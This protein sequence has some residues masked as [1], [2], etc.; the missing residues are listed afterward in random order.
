MN[1]TRRHLGDAY[2]VSVILEWENAL[3][4]GEDRASDMLRELGAQLAERRMI[5][6][7]ATSSSRWELISVFDPLCIT[8]AAVREAVE[9]SLDAETLSL[10]CIYLPAPSADYYA[11]KNL[12]VERANGIIVVLL[13]SDVVPDQG[14]LAELLRPFESPVVSIV[15]SACYIEPRGLVRKVLALIWVFEPRGAGSGLRIVGDR[16]SNS[17]AIANSTAYRREVFLSNPFDDSSGTARGS[18]ARQVARF[19]AMGIPVFRNY[20][21][22]LNHPAPVGLVAFPERSIA[23][24]RDVM[25]GRG[26]LRMVGSELRRG[27]RLFHMRSA[28]GLSVWQLPAALFVAFAWWGFMLTGAIATKVAPSYMRRH[29]LL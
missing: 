27:T 28:V 7:S 18:C 24:G 22:R 14:W 26:W 16:W 8:E 29:F 2:T 12:G 21:A 20:R 15:S 25:L 10:D 23:R 17:T 1:A 13:D 6:D 3:R 11:M 5:L 19:R 4:S 9:R